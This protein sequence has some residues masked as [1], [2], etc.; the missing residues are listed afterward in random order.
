MEEETVKVLPTSSSHRGSRKMSQSSD[1]RNLWTTATLSQPQLNIELSQVCENFDEEG[2]EIG[3]TRGWYTQKSSWEGEED[4]TNLN[5]EELNEHTLLELELHRGG[6]SGTVRSH[7]EEERVESKNEAGVLI[8][9]AQHLEARTPSRLLG[10]A[11]EQAA[12]APDGTHG[13]R[14]SGNPHQSPTELPVRHRQE[15]FPHQRAAAIHRG[16]QEAPEQEAARLSELRAPSWVHRLQ[17][18]VPRPKS[19]PVLVEFGS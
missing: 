17:P 5:P 13:E 19:N 2:R 18:P 14:G 7:F 9:I 8:V 11:A 4:K 15:P 3:K 12:A 10:R 6:S 1:I 16:T